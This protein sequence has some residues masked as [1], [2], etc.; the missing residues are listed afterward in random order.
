MT[1]LAE[2]Q[3]AIAA[4]PPQEQAALVKW[5]V[6]EESPEMLAAIDEADRSF[7]AEGGVEA[8]EVRRNLKL[9]LTG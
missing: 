2:I 9:W 5:L 6:E 3:E 1:K 7:V 8:G 4:L